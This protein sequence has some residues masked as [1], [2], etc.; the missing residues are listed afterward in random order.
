MYVYLNQF[1][2]YIKIYYYNDYIKEIEKVFIDFPLIS[3]YDEYEYIQLL[4]SN[5]I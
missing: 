1:Y 5:S 4:I 3:I 2:L